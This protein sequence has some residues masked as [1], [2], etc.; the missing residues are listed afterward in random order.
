MK[1]LALMKALNNNNNNVHNKIK[2]H[3][4]VDIA[5]EEPSLIVSEPLM[6]PL[7]SSC[8]KFAHLNMLCLVNKRHGIHDILTNN[9]CFCAA[10]CVVRNHQES[11]FR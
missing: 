11:V 1:A 2:V 10:L 6:K 3:K 7:L 4:G 8:T 9:P 5:R